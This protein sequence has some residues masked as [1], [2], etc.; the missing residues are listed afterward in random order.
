LIILFCSPDHREVRE[1]LHT[2]TKKWME[3]FRDEHVPFDTAKQK[4][5]VDS[6]AA[7]ARWSPHRAKSGALKGRPV[8]IL[9]ELKL[10]NDAVI[11]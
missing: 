1:K 6:D 3:K 11:K 4:V 8:D 5:Y 9:S 7:R 10:K 2:L